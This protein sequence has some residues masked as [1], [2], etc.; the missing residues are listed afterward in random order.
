MTP[1]DKQIKQKIYM[2]LSN[3]LIWM[4]IFISFIILLFGLSILYKVKYKVVKDNYNSIISQ[5]GSQ[6]SEYENFLSGFSKIENY[7]NSINPAD[8]K[9]INEILPEKPEKEKLIS[10]LE[11]LVMQNGLLMTGIKITGGKAE[12]PVQSAN[13]IDQIGEL[14]VGIDIMG[15][16]YKSLI[17]LL[18]SLENNL[19]IINIKK[20]SFAPNAALNLEFTT[21]YLKEGKY[22]IKNT[23]QINKSFLESKQYRDLASGPDYDST[24]L[25][26]GREDPF[27]P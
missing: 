10:Q 5:Q 19:R 17:S 2:F 21:Y 26:A 7:Y 4:V 18:N 24:S 9:N 8:I 16:N 22:N 1:I 25:R 13:P 27:S 11:K 12:D 14:K 20:L 23:A 3:Y 6:L 15:S